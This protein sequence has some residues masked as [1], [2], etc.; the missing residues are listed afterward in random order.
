MRHAL[1]GVLVAFLLVTACASTGT[2]AYTKEAEA[3][4]GWDDVRNLSRAGRFYF[5]GQPGEDAFDRFAD[6]GVDVVVNLRS[7]QEVDALGF[8]ESAT[9]LDAGMTYVHIPVTPDT[10]S[11]ADVDR[12]AEVL[13][14]SEGK[15]LVHCSS[16]NRVGGL[17]AAYL[18]RKRDVPLE[19][20]LEL[21]EAAGLSRETMVQATRTVAEAP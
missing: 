16:S 7:Q 1:T 2:S 21:G 10:F 17:W 5:A 6:Q 3:V 20:A 8:D 11:T 9:V 14:R 4:E 15:I 18:A 19:E 12:F 13:D